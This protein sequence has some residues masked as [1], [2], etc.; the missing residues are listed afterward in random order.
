MVWEMEPLRRNPHK[1]F[2]KVR[3]DHEIGGRITPLKFREANG[4]PVIID[5]ILDVRPAPSL[6]AGGQGIR[7]TCRV[8]DKEIYLF[9]DR[10][11]WF[12]EVD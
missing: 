5:R 3:A 9:H 2:V 4:E 11:L 8:R 10:D 7:Y 12:I 6:K 1:A